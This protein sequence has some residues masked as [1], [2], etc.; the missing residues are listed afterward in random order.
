MR[1]KKPVSSTCVGADWYPSSVSDACGPPS[2]CTRNDATTMVAA[3][4]GG[5]PRWSAP[6]A[7][8]TYDLS[9]REVDSKYRGLR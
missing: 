7:V 1:D 2:S 8:A 6:H 4:C 9:S 3:R 5:E